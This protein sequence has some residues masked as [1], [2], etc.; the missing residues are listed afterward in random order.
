MSRIFSKSKLFLQS[1]QIRLRQS[2]LYVFMYE[3]SS[4]FDLYY[5]LN[6]HNV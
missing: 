2:W 1:Q 5:F 6:F 3:V 4:D